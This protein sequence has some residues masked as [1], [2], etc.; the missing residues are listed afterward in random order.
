MKFKQVFPIF[1]LLWSFASEAV[2]LDEFI[3]EMV[4][5]HRFDKAYLVQLFEKTEVQE[6][7]IRLMTPKPSVGKSGPWYRYRQKFIS[8]GRVESGVKFWRKHAQTLKRAEIEYGV[9]AK[10]I[11]AIIGVETIFGA[12]QGNYRVLNALTTLAFYVERR[13]DFFR[14]ELEHFL[15]MTREQGINPLTLKGS[16]AGAMGLGQFMPSSYRNYAIDFNGDGKKDIWNDVEDAIG[17]I[18]NYFKQYGWKT[19]EDIVEAT[20][21]SAEGIDFLANLDMK[22]T[23]TLNYLKKRGLLFYGAQSDQSLGSFLD[24]ETEQGMAYWVI[25]ENFYVITRYNHSE[26]YAMA[27]YQLGQE[28]ENAYEQM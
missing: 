5:K 4:I 20:Q 17:S 12:N 22:P 13:A 2:T 16:Y 18:A 21:V 1:L 14:Q 25:F 23:H 28:I 24:L 8:D 11:V 3:D 7:A 9:P 6:S 26:R 19:G 10:I 27:V 15:L